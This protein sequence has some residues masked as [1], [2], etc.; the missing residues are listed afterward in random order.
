MARFNPHFD[1]TKIYPIANRWVRDCLVDDRSLFSSRLLWT[2]RYIG[3][4]FEAFVRNPI[5]TPGISFIEKLQQQL[6]TCAPEVTQLMAEVLYVLTLFQ[7]NM[8]PATKRELVGTIWSWSGATLP[9]D[10]PFLEDGGLG[11]MPSTNR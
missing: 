8:R 3:E 1:V 6:S 9:A 11:G 2:P 5:D 4:L 10:H 7:S